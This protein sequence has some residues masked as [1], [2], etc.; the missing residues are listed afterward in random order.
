M[1]CVTAR[2]ER[3]QCLQY[4]NLCQQLRVVDGPEPESLGGIRGTSQGCSMTL[5]TALSSIAISPAGTSHHASLA[6]TLQQSLQFIADRAGT[7]E[8]IVLNDKLK[9]LKFSVGSWK[10]V[11]QHSGLQPPATV[12]FGFQSRSALIVFLDSCA[13]T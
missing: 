10:E 11:V 3:G 9:S 7:P 1:Q 12:C 6:E 4:T 8:L 13:D 5:R 2:E